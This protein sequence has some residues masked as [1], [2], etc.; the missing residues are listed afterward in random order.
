MKRIVFCCFL[1]FLFSSC[2]RT[3]KADLTELTQEEGK[4]YNHRSKELYTGKVFIVKLE[5]GFIKNGLIEGKWIEYD[6]TNGVKSF[7]SFYF[8]GKK[9]GN[10]VQYCTDGTKARESFYKNGLKEGKEIVYSCTTPKNVKTIEYKEGVIDGK[11]TSFYEYPSLIKEII[12]YKDGLIDGRTQRFNKK[13]DVVEI[14]EYKNNRLDGKWVIFD[15][16]QNIVSE[17]RYVDGR[18]VTMSSN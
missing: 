10:E 3:N 17:E 6:L 12:E 5:C 16:S 14:I 4:Y 1:Y 9:N 18:L 7:E 11:E 13:G 8:N 2:A 15:D